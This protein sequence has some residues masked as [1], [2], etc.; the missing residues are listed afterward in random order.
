MDCISSSYAKEALHSEL[1]THGLQETVDIELA[2]A[3]HPAQAD[4]VVAKTSTAVT[5]GNRT[6]IFRLL[7]IVRVGCGLGTVLITENLELSFVAQSRRAE[8]YDPQGKSS[9]ET[10]EQRK[11]P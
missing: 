2:N 7:F 10:D 4:N 11:H 3:P 5:I 1:A 8:L 9:C 6:F